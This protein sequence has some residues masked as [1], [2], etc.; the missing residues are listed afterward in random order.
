MLSELESYTPFHIIHL[1][2]HDMT[3]PEYLILIINVD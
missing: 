2:Q 3:Q 1:I